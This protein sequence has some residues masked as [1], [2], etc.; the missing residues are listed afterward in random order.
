MILFDEKKAVVL[1]QKNH[2]ARQL[3]VASVAAA[4]VVCGL[5]LYLLEPLGRALCQLMA[6]AATAVCGCL[7]LVQVQNIRYRELLLGL[8]QKTPGP[9]C[10]GQVQSVQPFSTT[11]GRLRFYGVDIAVDGK[12]KVFYL[13]WEASADPYLGKTVHF[14]ACDHILLSVEVVQ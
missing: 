9:V 10:T 12:N 5:C 7:C 11:L 8:C 2:K 14:T 4:V 3:A 1:R 13:Y 6:T